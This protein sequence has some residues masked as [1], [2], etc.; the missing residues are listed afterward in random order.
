MFIEAS[1]SLN[2]MSIEVNTDDAIQAEVGYTISD[3]STCSRLLLVEIMGY[4]HCPAPH[5]AGLLSLAFVNQ[6][7]I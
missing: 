3:V 2:S 7:S 5:L 1:V 4:P 6:P